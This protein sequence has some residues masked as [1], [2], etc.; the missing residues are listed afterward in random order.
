MRLGGCC[1]R[2]STSKFRSHLNCPQATNSLEFQRAMLTAQCEKEATF[3]KYRPPIRTAQELSPPGWYY[4]EP[5]L[6]SPQSWGGVSHSHIEA[7]ISMQIPMQILSRFN[8]SI[9]KYHLLH[10][11]SLSILP[12]TSFPLPEVS[13]HFS[14]HTSYRTWYYRWM[15]KRSLLVSARS[16]RN[17]HA[18]WRGS[19]K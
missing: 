19:R 6:P 1:A 15:C 16:M 14:V 2:V 10:H 4:S 5:S 12:K 13:R 11:E 18:G 7:Y 17:S 9:N 8:T 3:P